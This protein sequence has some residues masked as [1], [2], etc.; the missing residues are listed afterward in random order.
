MC[1]RDRLPA[2][3][4]R[5]ASAQRALLAQVRALELEIQTL[6]H[7]RDARQNKGDNAGNESRLVQNAK[8]QSGGELMQQ[9]QHEL[10][11]LARLNTELIASNR[12][13]VAANRD[14][15][16]Q[17]ANLPVARQ[18]LMQQLPCSAGQSE[19]APPTRGPLQY[20]SDV[21]SHQPEPGTLISTTKS[22]CAEPS[23]ISAAKDAAANTR[24]NGTL[25]LHTL[26]AAE[27][28]SLIHI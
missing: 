13:L 16:A 10:S 15:I 20:S 11:E 7:S 9:V 26:S 18:D 8:D 3:D 27:E 6:Q 28:L 22:A 24:V 12:N 14:L 19:P 25:N 2:H 4:H 17:Q 23:S 5:G 21:S 1:I